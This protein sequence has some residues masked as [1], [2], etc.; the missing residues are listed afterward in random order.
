MTSIFQQQYI[1]YRETG[2]FTKIVLDYL[3]DDIELRPF[4]EH[5]MSLEG[6]R[7][8]I[9][10]REKIPVNRK[11]LH[12]ELMK[13]YAEVRDNNAVIDNIDCL[14][15]EKTFTVCTAHQP[16][17]F[18]GHL[19]FIY[20]IIHAIKLADI[21]TK[22]LPGYKFVPVFFMGSEDADLAE[23]NHIHLDGK[24]YE[25]NTNQKGAVGKMLVDKDL[26][27]LIAAF[28]GRLLAEPFGIE[29]VTLLK[30]CFQ[31]GK[32]IEQATF[33]FVHAVFHQYGLIVFLP[34]N[35][36]FKKEMMAIFEDDIFNHT[37]AK[38]VN[39]TS[40]VLSG[41]HHAQAFARDINLFYMKDDIRNRILKTG[42]SFVVHDT[43]IIFSKEEL[44]KE[45]QEHPERFSPNVILRG[46]FQERLLPDIAFIGGGGE[47]AYWLQ[48]KDLFQHYKTPY[49]VLFLR[50][51]FMIV[52]KK[53]T[54]LLEKLGI[55]PRDLFENEEKLFQSIVKRDS[56][57]SLSL[58][59][60]KRAIEKIYAA[61]DHKAM[62]VD[63]TLKDHISALRTRQ[64]NK[65]ER[66]EKKF[67]AAEKKKHEATGRQL[68]KIFSALLPDDGLQER[69]DNFML[70]Y[71]TR[72]H[73]LFDEI[74]KAS[75]VFEPGFCIMVEQ[76][77][78]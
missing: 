40:E 31:K 76:N 33:L 73:D 43:D 58:Q 42:D 78:P 23:L 32:T 77:I 49:P 67:I 22:D 41:H 1:P 61:I 45:L 19:Y 39:K 56:D 9:H 6:I 24:K 18:T 4:I 36:A 50:N 75:T 63:I 57:L 46:L 71:A 3:N 20:K 64:L 2:K 38:I 53:W 72:G 34:D 25:W 30:E 29:L 47:L 5:K 14:L 48:L 65:L 28:E 11:L 62:S 7:K 37:P 27:E 54:D 35:A 44:K 12:K 51:S 66:V 16:N 60:E 15:D 26:L 13:Q 59:D 52:N 55:Q 70:F 21:L 74:Y 69:S 68:H 10:D 8:A 17:L